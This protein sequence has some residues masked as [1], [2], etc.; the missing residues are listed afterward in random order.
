MGEKLPRQLRSASGH[1]TKAR[2]K[3]LMRAAA[4]EIERLEARVLELEENQKHGV[5]LEP[6]AAET[7]PIA[8][9]L[10]GE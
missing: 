5:I 6:I 10:D 4:A 7:L 1:M 2:Y 8:E 9:E 3:T